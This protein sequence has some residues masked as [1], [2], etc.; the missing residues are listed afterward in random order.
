[1]SRIRFLHSAQSRRTKHARYYEFEVGSGGYIMDEQRKYYPELKA[2]QCS[3]GCPD[4]C[5]VRIE[6][7]GYADPCKHPNGAEPQASGLCKNKNM[8]LPDGTL[9]W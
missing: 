6:D 3:L 7:I 1:M 5:H 9:A 4:C 2:V 8:P